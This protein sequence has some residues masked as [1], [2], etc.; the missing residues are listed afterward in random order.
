MWHMPSL[1]AQKL[2]F[3]NYNTANGLTHNRTHVIRQDGKGYIWIGTDMGINRYDGR[4]F[5]FFPNPGPAYQGARYAARY[6]DSIIFSIDFYG[7]AVCYGDSVRFVKRALK[8]TVLINGVAWINDSTYLVANAAT[9]LTLMTQNNAKQ[10]L[11]PYPVNNNWN[12]TDLYKDKDN[13]IW[14]LCGDALI[15]IKNGDFQHT[16]PVHFFDKSFM[17]FVRQ[18]KNGDI[19]IAGQK[20]LFRYSREQIN[21]INDSPP[22]QLLP[23]IADFTSITFDAYDNL[24]MSSTYKGLLKYNLKSGVFRFYGTQNGLVS[25]NTWDAFCDRESNIW[26]GSENGVSKLTTQFYCSFDFTNTEYQNVKNSC[27]WND[28]TI[29]LCNQIDLFKFARDTFKKIRGY[30]NNPGYIKDLLLKTPDNKLLTDINIPKKSGGF[31]VESFIYDLGESTVFNKRKLNDLQGGVTSVYLDQGVIF[32]D[33]RVFVNTPTGFK[34]YKNGKMLPAAI[35]ENDSA[36]KRVTNIAATQNGDYWFILNYR[37][38]VRY[39]RISQRNIIPY[40][41]KK[42]DY[43]KS[44]EIGNVNLSSIFVDSRGIIWVNSREKGACRIATDE[45]GN[46]RRIEKTDSNM[47]SSGMIIDMVEDKNHNIW[48]ATAAG[49]DKITFYGDKFNVEKGLYS[50]ELCGKYIYF[51]RILNDKLFVGTSGCVGVIDLYKKEPNVAPDVYIS[52]IKINEVNALDKLLLKPELKTNENTFNFTFTA[53]NYK[54]ERHT[55]YSYILEGLDK[56]WSAPSTDYR[57]VYSQLPPGEYT[58]K[59]KALSANGVWSVQPASFQFTI[60]QP[61]YTRWWFVLLALATISGI[62]YTVYRYRINQ[63]L[64]IHRIRQR[65]SKDLHDDIGATVSSI[66]ILANM[67]KSDLV[68]E[69]KRNQFLETIQEES[70]HVSDSLNDIVWSIN[71]K[72]DSLEIMFARMQRYASELFEAKNIIYNFILPAD[73]TADMN[74]EMASRQHI[75]LIFKEAINNLVKY[76]GASEAEVTFKVNNSAFSFVITDNGIGFDTNTAYTGNGIYNMQKRAEDIK[77][78]LIIDSIPG[79]GTT[80]RLTLP[81]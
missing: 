67:A 77:G 32:E 42:A 18:N 11:L 21:N 50:N 4:S 37:D 74:M 48:V 30:K 64:K 44:E 69:G 58:F 46:V 73:K 54:D 19:Y 45:N 76:S 22:Q 39:K 27:I 52:G 34:I 17:N 40:V 59:V 49:V 7:I 79:S 8:N 23:P 31:T 57:V 47:F 72:N 66:N 61:F 68:S 53:I 60:Q 36:P 80:V 38:V 12:F 75:Y 5:K 3:T 51:V 63:L 15:F 9:G 33:D 41:F 16:V 20:G 43:F 10:I 6:K 25:Q 56:K 55:K 78:S 29:L 35:F 70:K 24:W 65:I 13:N 62:I 14:V 81:L 2:P 26:V 1:Y 71:P 28:S